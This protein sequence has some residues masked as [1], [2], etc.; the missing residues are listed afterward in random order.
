MK[1]KIIRFFTT[2]LLFKLVSLGFAV[3]LWIYV[4]LGQTESEVPAKV[5]VETKNLSRS[6]IRT[7][8]LPN[9]LEI[10]VRGPRTVLRGIRDRQLR[11]V[12][13]LMGALPGPMVAKVYA[14]KIE[15]L[16]NGAKVTEIVPSQI[17]ITISERKNKTVRVNPIFRGKPSEGLEVLGTL[18]EPELVEI[19]GAKEEVDLLTEVDTEIID[20]TG[21]AKTF[22]VEVGLDL[23]NRHVEAVNDQSVKITV[24]IGEPNISRIFYGIP[25]EVRN[26]ATECRLNRAELDVQLEGAQ[27]P[28]LQLTPNELKLVLD[29]GGLEPG[30]TYEVVP[31]LK[32]PEGMGFRKVNM[33][34]VKVTILDQAKKSGK[35][36]IK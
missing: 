23:I 13:D 22:S 2:N 3:V 6:L 25:I 18:V 36:K 9:E 28:L 34:P 30:G 24:Q 12:I 29:A 19:S 32:V 5:S 21:H 11:Y 35:K 26:C 1:Q 20:L 4:S 31:D 10:K 33:P 8:D 7:S 14:P 17:Q 27:A 15:G 16:S